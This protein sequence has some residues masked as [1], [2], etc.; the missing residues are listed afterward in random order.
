MDE[1]HTEGVNALMYA[2]KLGGYDT[3][4]YLMKKADVDMNAKDSAGKNALHF[5]AASG[6]SDTIQALLECD[7]NV[8]SM[9]DDGMTPLMFA[10]RRKDGRSGQDDRGGCGG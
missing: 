5:A 1:M 9:T 4:S 8:D 2:A 3:V 6:S 10:S 7:M